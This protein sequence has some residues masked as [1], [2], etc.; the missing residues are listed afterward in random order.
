MLNRELND[1]YILSKG[2]KVYEPT[3]FHNSS[4][5]KCFQKRFDDD[6][7]KKY[8]IDI[9][10]WSWKSFMIEGKMGIWDKDTTYEYTTQLYR[11]DTHD[12]VDISFHSSWT[13]EQ[14]EEHMEK[15]FETGM[16]DYY[17]TWDEC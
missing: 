7:G 2:Y 17:E 12:A 16:Y 14:V 8:F 3:R 15:L 9:N 11:K 10:K 5:I 1:E 6:K 4:I 13:L